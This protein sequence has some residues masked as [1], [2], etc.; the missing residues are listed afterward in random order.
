MASDAKMNLLDAGTRLFAEHG[1]AGASVRDICAEAGVGRNM[2]H[3]YF[4]NKEGLLQAILDDFSTEAFAPAIRLIAKPATSHD[5]F[6]LKLDLF[7]A[8]VFEVLIANAAIFRI[9][10][11]EAGTFLPLTEL[12]EGLMA[13]LT[14]AKDAQLLSAQLDVSMAPGFI[15]DRL[16]GQVLY[17]LRLGETTEGN[18]ILTPAYRADWL[19]ANTRLLLFGLAAQD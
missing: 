4:G 19:A 5:E 8:E 7:I 17:A 16:G 6:R 18:V 13:Y 1:F 15:L 14:S 3:H 11:R 12:R 2:I 9:M 10:S